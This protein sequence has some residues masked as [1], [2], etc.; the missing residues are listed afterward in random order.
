MERPFH[1]RP[2][3]PTFFKATPLFPPSAYA[4]VR[5]PGRPKLL[6]CFNERVVRKP[7]F[8]ELVLGDPSG[9]QLRGKPLKLGAHLEHLPDIATPSRPDHPPPTLRFTPNPLTP[10]PGKD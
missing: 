6:H 10:T 8:H 7:Q 3:L 2:P 9:R 5:A 1:W 4:P